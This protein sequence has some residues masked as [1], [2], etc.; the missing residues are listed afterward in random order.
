M[1]VPPYSCGVSASR[2]QNSDAHVIKRSLTEGSA[3]TPIFERHYPAV[4]RFL[5]AHWGPEVGADLASETFLR[6]YDQRARFDMSKDSARPWLF[7]IAIN[8]SR[9]EARRLHRESRAYERQGRLDELL[10]FVDSAVLRLDAHRQADSL[11]L[12]QVLNQLRLEDLTVLTMSVLGEMTHTEIAESMDIP[13]GTV[14]SRLHRTLTALRDL[15]E[16]DQD[17]ETH[18]GPKAINEE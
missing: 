1:G 13:I 5:V 6:A 12:F 14:K 16:P 4:H 7:G 10:D 8:L 15:F 11:E 3:F 18:P 2:A 9:M 17:T